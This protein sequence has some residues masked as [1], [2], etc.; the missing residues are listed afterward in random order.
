[1]PAAIRVIWP[2]E[3]ENYLDVARIIIPPHQD[4]DSPDAQE[5]CDNLVFTPWHSLAA[6]QPVGGINRLRLDVYRTSA[7]HRQVSAE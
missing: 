5:S 2:E 1:L 7:M 4:V 3:E 6:H